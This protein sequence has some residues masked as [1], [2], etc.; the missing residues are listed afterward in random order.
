MC[1]PENENE[2]YIKN[3][4]EGKGIRDKATAKQHLAGGLARR[5]C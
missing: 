5:G 3:R 4:D 2:T 1:F